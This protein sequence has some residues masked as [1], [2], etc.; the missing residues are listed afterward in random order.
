[1][2]PFTLIAIYFICWWVVLFVVLPLGMNQGAQ[3][4]PEDGGDWGAPAKPNLKRKFITTT[5][6]AAI[7][8]LVLILAIQFQMIPLPEFQTPQ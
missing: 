1:M 2:G 7:V 5:W 4:R 6:V 8:W 3:T